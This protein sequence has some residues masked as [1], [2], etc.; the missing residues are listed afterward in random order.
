MIPQIP[1][2]VEQQLDAMTAAFRQQ[3]T[4][5]WQ[6]LIAD[7]E[8][9]LPATA[10]NVEQQIREWLRHI[11]ADTQG[12][13]LGQVERYRRKG[14]RAC[15]GCHTEVYWTRYAQ[16]NYI[17]T[18]GELTLERAYY[19]HGSCH[20][21]W[22]PL[23]A[24]LQLGASELSPLV[25]EMSS[26]LG[27]W[28]PF[29]QVV[30]YLAKYQEIHISHDTVNASTVRVGHALQEQQAA[31]IHRAWEEQVLPEC[32]GVPPQ[33]LYIS[34]DGIHHLLP[35][36]AG[37]EIKLAAIYETEERQNQ[38]GETEIHA[39]NIDYVV[40]T[41]GEEL[42]K[43]AYLRAVQRG[44][45]YVD[46]IGVLGDGANW[47]WNRVAAMF[48]PRKTTEIGDFYHASEYVWAAAQAVW[49]ADTAQTKAWSA[50]Q[51]HTLKH[52]GPHAVR[53]A[54]QALPAY[55]DPIPK[56]VSAART[57]FTNQYPRMDYPRYVAHGWQI[58]SGS[59][60]SG[61]KQVVGM[62]LNQAGMRW[63]AEHAVAVAYA[64]AAILSERGDD[65]W[66]DFQPPARHYQRQASAMA[67]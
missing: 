20:T 19:H 57:Y 29:E 17:S 42:A 51:C 26:Y 31:A 67:A 7:E 60:E 50:Q 16:R 36:G 48:P 63:N 54:L 65:F 25:Q 35:T 62:R 46:E 6:W 14:K 39:R 4:E 38:K 40:A 12:L 58:G 28:M 24:Q 55:D 21:G 53:Q 1:P 64:R 27:A 2:E 8:S 10:A 33:R 11:G 56:A 22:V 49:G 45:E 30:Q 23:D 43:A 44:V 59:A 37:K 41:S 32:E 3:L 18:L 47:I 15:P 34:A 66:T 9:E 61:V 13:L 5:L 52:D